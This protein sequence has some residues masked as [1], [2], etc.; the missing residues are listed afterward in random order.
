MDTIMITK[1][2]ADAI[3]QKVPP[4][5][6]TAAVQTLVVEAIGTSEQ[7]SAEVTR[8]KTEITRLGAE[9]EALRGLLRKTIEQIVPALGVRQEV[10][11]QAETVG[12]EPPASEAETVGAEVPQ[13]GPEA[14][15]APVEA[16]PAPAEATSDETSNGNGAHAHTELSQAEAEALMDSAIANA[17]KEKKP[18]GPPPP[19]HGGKRRGAQAQK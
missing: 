8:L 13:A 11:P 16:A 5:R 10:P 19:A 18:Q 17:E 4:A 2:K 14:Q 6:R 3:I 9:V 15:A 1:A 12:A 7:A